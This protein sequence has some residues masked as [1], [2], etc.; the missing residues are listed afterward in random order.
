MT[1]PIHR[2]RRTTA[3]L[4]AAGLSIGGAL[5]VPA[6]AANERPNPLNQHT[7]PEVKAALVAHPRDKIGEHDRQLLAEAVARGEKTVTA[8]LAVDQR[9]TRRVADQ[10]RGIGAR[11]D[12]VDERV[13]YVRAQVPP[14]KVEQAAAVGGVVAL[15]LKEYFRPPEPAPE[16]RVADTARVPAPG[17]GTPDA[18]PY[19]PTHETG[20][21]RFRQQHPSWD[22]RGVTIGILDTGVDLDHP[23]L[24]KTTTGQR[25]IVDS[26]TATDPIYDGDATWR[27][28]ITSVIGP[29]FV[30][31]G[32]IWTAPAGEYKINV[33]TEKNTDFPGCAPTDDIV[34]GDLNRDGDSDD[35]FGILYRP[36]DHAVWVDT[37][38]DRDF[39]DEQ[40]MRPY[41]VSHQVGHLGQDK[42]GTEV[43]ETLPF[44]VQYR[45]DVELPQG[46]VADFVNLG[47]IAGAHGTHVAGITAAHRMFGGRMNGAAPGAQIVSVRGCLFGPGCSSVALVE[48]MIWLVADRHVDV[49]NLSIGGLPALND[50]NNARAELYNRLIRQYGVQLFISAGNSGAGL[51][52]VGDPSVADDVVSVGAAISK[53]TWKANYGAEVAYRMGVFNFSSRGPREDGG[54]KPD[55]VAPGSAI[56]SIPVQTVGQ[57]V[58]EAGYSLPV[59]Y[60]MFNGT[61]MAAPQAT[62]AA[63]LLLSAA[64]QTGAQATPAQ[65]R[66][67]VF[68]A[69]KPIAGIPVH[70]QGYG[71][72]DVPGAWN[73]LKR[74][75]TPDA[76]TVSAPVCTPLSDK[77]ATPHQGAGV[78]N[79]CAAGGHEPGEAKD[80]LVT[81]TRA[82][83]D[84]RPKAYR[85]SLQGNDGTFRT[86]AS[87]VTLPR[88]VPVKIRL[89]AA[90]TV[91][92]HSA[93]LRLDDPATP[94]LDLG[95]LNTVVAAPTLDE[96]RYTW[97]AT[98]SVNR[99]EYRSYFVSV[100]ADTRVL[101]VNLADV[102]DGSQTRWI[103]Y[104]PWGLPVE[105][106][107][108][109][110][111]YTNLGGGNGCDPASRFYA[112]PIPGVW[113]FVVESRRTSPLLENP[114]RL[115]TQA[116]GITVTPDPVTFESLPKGQATG[117]EV[118][119]RNDFGPVTVTPQGGALGSLLA[120][121]RTITKGETHLYTV[122]VPEGA[123]RFEVAIGN[124][125]DPA[126]DLDLT[127]RKDGVVVGRSADGDSDEVVTLDEPEPGTYEV[128]VYGYETK[129]GGTSYDY[130]EVVFA[131]RYG[132]VTAP[133][134]AISL[135]NG[136]TVTVTGSVTIQQAPP[137]GHQL[138]G[139]VPLVSPAG[140]AVG[141]ATVVIE[142][143]S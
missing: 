47:V 129:P 12:R 112:H 21:V 87:T 123:T 7:A 27:A 109:L 137:G 120:T 107:S 43:R 34:C 55:I 57:P 49:V 102:A 17:P 66:Q 50:A 124:P 35:V 134:D 39:T 30:Y 13:G 119:A 23:A 4:V 56:S 115:T 61:S 59:G 93:I 70:V 73:L 62:G 36:G 75:L 14:G 25:K 38:G 81:V 97:Q 139:E 105:S 85:L 71:M 110:V 11:V 15:D 95:V 114:F 41:G 74:D 65:L 133:G 20:A 83:G 32:Q 135:A 24:Q 37:D 10:L 113:E 51:N 80:Y 48:G 141:T 64:R 31:R 26:V 142:S 92:A 103:A 91:G 126:A 101:Q 72:F 58:P 136:Q 78:Y 86:Y 127:V 42:P 45:E 140:A 46:G 54:F 108:S 106:T 121:T 67:A 125:G 79:R 2:R 88:G 5:A 132:T 118:T 3:L 40:L 89:T 128:E 130:R 1:V 131:P 22:G 100:P 98:G 6:T 82:S 33:V 90:P 29:V 94:G 52:T 99:N 60:G 68:S 16:Q 69:A 104:N 111:C 53:A 28:M 19:L 63:A 18:N 76:F 143:V 117:F 96:P 77:L 84:P 116:Q 122:Q 44:V 138:Y 8:M 9:Q